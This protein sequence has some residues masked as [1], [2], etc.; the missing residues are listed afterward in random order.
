MMKALVEN[1][2]GTGSFASSYEREGP[3]ATPD[4]ALFSPD[5]P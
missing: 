3:M 1:A 5:T 2:R 4:M